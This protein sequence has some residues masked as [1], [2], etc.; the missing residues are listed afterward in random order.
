ME[1]VGNK[2]ILT[3]EEITQIIVESIAT[4]KVENVLS[5]PQLT[6]GEACE[7]YGHER[8]KK[9]IKAGL[10]KKESQ[11]GLTSKIYYNHLKIINLSK[12]SHHYLNHI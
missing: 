4:Y 5:K 3:R 10:L 6:R 2:Y 7:Y 8:V 12:E 9:W 11:N 1:I